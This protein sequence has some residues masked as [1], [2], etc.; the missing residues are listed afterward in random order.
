MLLL[1]DKVSN[2]KFQIRTVVPYEYYK[3]ISQTSEARQAITK[4]QISKF[5]ISKFTDSNLK[6]SNFEVSKFWSVEIV[7]W[8][9]FFSNFLCSICVVFEDKGPVGR[10]RPRNINWIWF[11]KL[12]NLLYLPC[13]TADISYNSIFSSPIFCWRWI[14]SIGYSWPCLGII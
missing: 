2:F 10:R 11:E 9:A 3:I 7:I 13:K 6:D 4:Y 12:E 8:Y 14:N 5:E 1:T